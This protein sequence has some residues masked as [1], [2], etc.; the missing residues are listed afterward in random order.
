MS[1]PP[2]ACTDCGEDKELRPYGKGGAWVCFACAMKD[3]P[4][5][6]RRMVAAL[7]AAEAA[8]PNGIA[9]IGA[10]GPPRSLDEVLRDGDVPAALA[11]IHS[12]GRS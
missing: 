7:D 9:V 5:A 10:G 8:D 2:K 3:K 1:A 11:L 6:E 12:G 4:E